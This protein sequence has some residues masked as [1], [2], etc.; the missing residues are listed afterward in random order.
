MNNNDKYL[1]LRDRI[2]NC[3]KNEISKLIVEIET[4]L[5]GEINKNELVVLNRMLAILHKKN[6]DIVRA[7]FYLKKVL[8]IGM[9]VLT[10]ERYKELQIDLGVYYYYAR[11]YH[12]SI[13]IYLNVLPFFEIKKNEKRVAQLSNNLG[14]VYN[15]LHQFDKALKYYQDCKK[16]R[17][18]NN[19]LEGLISI[20]NNIGNTYFDKK[21]YEDAFD[22]HQKSF[23]LAKQNSNTIA[24]GRSYNNIGLICKK[25]GQYEKALYYLFEAKKIN[26]ENE[27]SWGIANSY[28]NVGDCYLALN[29]FQEARKNL[30]KGNDIA[31]RIGDKKL[32]RDS[33]EGL[34]HLA[35][36]QKNY[37]RA[38]DWYK[39]M[40]S[41]QNKLVDKEVSERIA[42]LEKK[43]QFDK[44]LQ[45]AEIQ[46][47]R[48]VEL[49]KVNKKLEL[50][51]KKFQELNTNLENR[52]VSEIK[53]R[54]EQQEK[55]FQQARLASLG[56]LASGIA[57][58]INQ[59][60]HSLS[61]TIENIRL[62][63]EEKTADS[64]YLERK[65][66]FLLQDIS[67]MRKII[68]HIR[69]FSRNE[70]D[71]SFQDFQLNESIYNAVSMV[72]E[73]YSNHGVEI[74][75][76]LQEN[77]PL[78]SG[79]IYK[80]EQVVLNLLSNSHDALE[81]KEKIMEQVYQKKIEIQTY[82]ANK[83]VVMLFEDN[84]LG[85]SKD[86]QY[87]IF[88]PFFTTKDPGKGTGLGLSISYNIVRSMDGKMEI[89]K[90]KKNGFHLQVLL[91]A[92]EEK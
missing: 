43:Y 20:Y 19:D 89:L 74:S 29:L 11:D 36:K 35:Y 16:L 77:L 86:I 47:L 52:V 28:I 10:K 39:K 51:Q 78:I 60:L 57:H 25:K 48:N 68:D 31:A 56:E 23:H 85:L 44:R 33:Y 5:K 12:K 75:T 37:K 21:M 65:F 64:D 27:I 58:E 13:E 9:D 40:I 62:A 46:R 32:I 54:H 1:D 8:E 30:K 90:N 76:R 69:I 88:D 61:F 79:N 53:K 91:P 22:Y 18:K 7:I 70:I 67:R 6:D 92:K 83:N 66:A 72:R 49:V 59:P 84:G 63:I 4:I 82:C 14:V 26:Q 42:I 2:V 55:V 24:M 3:H 15:D 71:A 81:E 87:K 34:Y 50:S 38:F 45:E 73:Q 41:M 80:F 17:E